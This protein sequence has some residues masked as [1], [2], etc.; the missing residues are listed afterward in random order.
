MH[1][2]T[3]VRHRKGGSKEEEMPKRQSARD[4]P[5]VPFDAFKKGA[6]QALTNTKRESDR[7][8]AA[9]QA[10]NARR[11]NAKKKQ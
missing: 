3:I 8:L 4:I 6:R 7:Q 2:G 1:T 5:L 11:R 10:S 9:F